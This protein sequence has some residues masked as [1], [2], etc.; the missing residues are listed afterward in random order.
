MVG[1]MTDELNECQFPWLPSL[2]LTTPE[3]KSTMYKTIL[4]AAIVAAFAA[5]TASAA[6][7]KTT[8]SGKP[9]VSV[10]KHGA[11]DPAG[12]DRGNHGAGH[13]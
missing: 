4:S 7:P 3:R 2:H 11:D 12:D 5:S 9:L 1:G 13:A 10:A 8:Y 6:I